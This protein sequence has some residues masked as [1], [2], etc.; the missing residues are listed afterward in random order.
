M[1]DQNFSKLEK[2]LIERDKRL[3]DAYEKMSDAY[4]K[5]AVMMKETNDRNKIHDESDRKKWEVIERMVSVN[6]EIIS[7][8]KKSFR[9]L[10]IAVIALAVGKEVLKWLPM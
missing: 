10:L 4:Q 6:E 7:F 9:W 2:Y 3:V 5:M 1:T 8:I